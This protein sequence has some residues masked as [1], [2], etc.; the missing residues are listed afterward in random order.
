ME[1]TKDL[2]SQNQWSEPLLIKIKQFQKFNSQM[3]LLSIQLRTVIYEYFKELPDN[4]SID[5]I[6]TNP[7]C[8]M[9]SSSVVR[10]NNGILSPDY[11]DFKYQYGKIIEK[12]SSVE[13]SKIVET[14]KNMVEMKKFIIKGYTI[15]LHPQV[16]EFIK[17]ILNESYKNE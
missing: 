3:I 16:I 14:L 15:T 10:N 6:A 7:C 11:Y 13:D 2:L 4:P 8:F 9:V 1:E 17:P 12:I 5:R